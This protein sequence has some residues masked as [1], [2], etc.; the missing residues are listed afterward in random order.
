MRP[1][2]VRR[3]NATLAGLAFALI[4]ILSFLLTPMKRAIFVFA[5]LACFAASAF[6]QGAPPWAIQE[7]DGSPRVNSPT[8]IK[9]TNG[10]L[11]CTGKTCTITISGGG[12]GSPGGASGTVQWN[13][14]G[15]FNGT[16]GLTATATTVTIVS[17]VT[18]TFSRA[19][20][21][22]TG[23]VTTDN[24][25][26]QT[27]LVQGDRA[28]VTANDE[29][30]ITYR[31]SSDVGT[32]REVARQTWA[33]PTVTDGAENGRID[34]SVMTGGAL[35]K[36][37]QLAG[38]DL[39]PSTSDG[40]ALG[41]T[42]LMWSDLFLASGAV[43]NFNAGNV[44][45]TH[46]AGILT[47]GTGELRIT[48]VGTNA[49]SV[50]TVGSTNTFTNKTI[51]ASSNVLG[52]VTM[53]LGSDA[54]G[55]IYYRASGVLTR[56]P[57]GTAAQVLTMNA[58][59]TAP[60][61]A[62]GGGAG[63]QT[64]WTANVDADGFNLLFDD[65]TGIKSSEA[66]NPSLLLFTSVA[67]AVNFVTLTNAA[68]GGNSIFTAAGS[69]ADVGIN[70]TGKGV[71]GFVFTSTAT[72]GAGLTGAFNSLTTGQGASFASSSVTSGSVVNIAST[73]TAGATGVEGLN[74]AMSGANGT[75]A[76]TVTGATISVTNTNAT[77][78]TNIGL[79][80]TASG[81]TTA[82]TALN[83]TA[84]QIVT[85][86]GTV[87]LPAIGLGSTTNGLSFVVSTVVTSIGGVAQTGIYSAGVF[88]L[89]NGGY[90]AIAQGDPHTSSA[91]ISLNKAAAS[92]FRIGRGDASSTGA[93]SLII[94]TSAGAIGTS[95]AGVLAFTLSTAPST[96]P[97]DTVQL[98]S[99]DAA[100]GAH[101]LYARNE[102]G[103][104][105]RLTGNAARNSAAFTATS[106][107]T[108]TNI[109]GL[110]RNV[111][112]SRVYAFRAVLQT[113][114][115]ATGGVK[116][117]VSGTATATAI[118]YVGVL[119]D[120]TSIIANTR[121]TAL[122]ATVCASTTSTA[123]TCTI[124]GVLVVANAGTLTLQFAQNASDGS[125][126]T[127]LANQY[128]QLIPIS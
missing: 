62:A 72:T 19:G 11:S 32:Q 21:L 70:F 30:Y 38:A 126:S 90:F 107:T 59:A 103:E 124:E 58:G 42:S 77:S 68:T 10:T 1:S 37:L 54:D 100:A 41:T 49:A 91:D 89:R 45:L 75:N 96:S 121:A 99:N 55:D 104:I 47:M 35:A 88:A 6:G 119:T 82:N 78:G 73:S 105:N 31:M 101:A 16:S 3:D 61:W 76:Q 28:T 97:T 39:S 65:A 56:L 86:A 4:F 85:P 60:E 36:E 95:G 117:A 15:A 12:G 111:E 74:I 22:Y 113:T 127:V 24:A 33:I 106:S 25:S 98:Y 69:D 29:A 64:P 128:F 5:F 123:G 122:D 26:V 44:V 63:S 71:G 20:L 13:D 120:G 2:R 18:A 112:A 52:G 94:G 43:L 84:G 17:G 51:T 125:A 83:V 114:A 23:T 115:V 66:T 34:W 9:V 50:P 116:V 102:L 80:L 67:S 8:L 93:G 57:K 87:A 27:M 108:L 7:V 109:T 46:S 14:S 48:T 81:A 118:S 92:V 53:T 79:T 40:L 110:T